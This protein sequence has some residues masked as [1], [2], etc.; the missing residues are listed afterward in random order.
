[1]SDFDEKP[2]SDKA[3]HEGGSQQP[4][5]EPPRRPSPNP[6]YKRQLPMHST[7]KFLL[8]YIGETKQPDNFLDELIEHIASRFMFKDFPGLQVAFV[9]VADTLVEFSI[10]PFSS[11]GQYV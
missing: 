3:E 6:K 8:P 5:I 10:D 11:D 2:A 9:D 1:M 7:L 4:V